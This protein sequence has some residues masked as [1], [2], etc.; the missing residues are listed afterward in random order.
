MVLAFGIALARVLSVLRSGGW[1]EQYPSR[2]GGTY[3]SAFVTF[4]VVVGGALLGGLCWAVW[5]LVSRGRD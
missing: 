4:A 5:L 1:L 3:G 2:V